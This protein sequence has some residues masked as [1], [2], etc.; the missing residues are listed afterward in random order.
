[1]LNKYF[2]SVI[3]KED[4]FEENVNHMIKSIVN[5]VR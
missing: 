1:M 2:E 5:D 3:F 4:E